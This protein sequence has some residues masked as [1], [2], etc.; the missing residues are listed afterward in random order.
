MGKSKIK[1]PLMEKS[2]FH[3]RDFFCVF[4]QLLPLNNHATSCVVCK[5]WFNEF[6][7]NSHT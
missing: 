7:F 3:F 6:Y 5:H 4:G 1:E 2:N